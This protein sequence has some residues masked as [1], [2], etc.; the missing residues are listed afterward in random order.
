MVDDDGDGWLRISTQTRFAAM[1]S[2]QM[3]LYV[4]GTGESLDAGFQA[5]LW[6]CAVP[7]NGGGHPP[8]RRQ[9]HRTVARR[10]LLIGCSC[11]A[12]TGEDHS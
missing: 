9:A 4:F 7:H 3:L 8:K 2:R 6:L 12:P 5:P 11:D 1:A 10:A